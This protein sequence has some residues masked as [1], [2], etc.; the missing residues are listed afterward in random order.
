MGSLVSRLQLQA[1]VKIWRGEVV[2]LYKP[3]SKLPE[4]CEICPRKSTVLTNKK[5]DT[6]GWRIDGW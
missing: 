4:Y 1:A 2:G 6:D 5:L 3:F